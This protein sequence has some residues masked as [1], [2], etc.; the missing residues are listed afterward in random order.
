MALL[1]RTVI[2]G[3]RLRS[4]TKGVAMSAVTVGP[5]IS[6]HRSRVR[7]AHAVLALLAIAVLLAG[8]FVL[9]RSTSHRTQP[10]PV[11]AASIVS[12]SAPSCHV[13]RAC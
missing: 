6:T 12:P 7:P 8:A 9:G 10:R 3:P 1:R 11:P 13:G 4:E 2:L 5:S